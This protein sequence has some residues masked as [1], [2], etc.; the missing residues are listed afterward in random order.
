MEL[1]QFQ[2]WVISNQLRILA[3]LCPKEEAKSISVQREAIERGYEEYYDT[4]IDH[5]TMSNHDRAEVRDTL[6]M[7]RAIEVSIRGQETNEFE[8]HPLRKF[9]GY[10]GNNETEFMALT[11]YIMN[12]KGLWSE[13]LLEDEDLNSHG[14]MRCI[15]AKMLE[16]W[17]GFD[18]AERFN[19]SSEQIRLVLD[20]P[21]Y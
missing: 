12:R 19:M 2:R 13:L 15:Y 4:P 6:D 3:A 7:F 10:D 5:N 18:T 20:S 14:P 16:T 9:G 21:D 11:S 1:S 8:T 17:K